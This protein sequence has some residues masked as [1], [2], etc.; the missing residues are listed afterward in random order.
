VRCVQQ[1]ALLSQRTRGTARYSR[2]RSR[3]SRMG[4]ESKPASDH[5]SAGPTPRASRTPPGWQAS[6]RSGAA[7]RC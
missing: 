5:S 2:G 4:G 3:R 6:G 7:V 1:G